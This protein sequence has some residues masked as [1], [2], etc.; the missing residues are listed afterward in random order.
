MPVQTRQQIIKMFETYKNISV[1]FNNH[2][3]E[4]TGLL[5]KQIFLKISNL[6]VPCILYSTSMTTAKVIANL[7]PQL[8]DEIRSV[9]NTAYLRF[10][11]KKPDKADFLKFFVAS[12]I[13][14]FNP[15]SK[16]NPNTNFITLSYSQ[17]PP[18]DLIQILGNLLAIKANAM[19]RK[20]ERIELNDENLKKLGLKDKNAIIIIQDVPRKCILRDI[21]FSGSKMLIL[22]IG[23]FL[24][25]KEAVLRLSV[26]TSLKPID[27]KGK[28]TRTEEVKGRKDVS[29]IALQFDD[30][31]PL[32]FINNIN[33]FFS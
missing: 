21:S 2:V 15:Y 29:A 16:K 1:S 32:S 5:P 12:K 4:A 18:D 33:N 27:I 23:K 28:I 6:N 11:F 17:K 10:T 13:T 8:F 25:D 31:K 26:D 3:I 22:G 9:R 19:K 14:G 7:T 30:N 20:E 24:V